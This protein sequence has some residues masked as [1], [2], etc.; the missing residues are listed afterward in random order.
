MEISNITI[1]DRESDT[2]I[3]R[4]VKR[5]YPSITQAIIE[6]S[7]RNGLIKIDNKKV[8]SNYRVQTNQILTVAIA[9]TQFKS[10]KKQIVSVSDHIIN[11]FRRSILFYD[12]DIIVINKD[13]GLATQRG[14]KIKHSVDDII[15]HVEEFKDLNPKLVHRLDKDT[16][17][18]LII[19]ANVHSANS[20]TK[21]FREKV[22][23]K[24]YLALTL[25]K[26]EKNYGT[27]D[28]P[29]AKTIENNFEQVTKSPNANKAITNY[30]LI[31][32]ISNEVSLV[33]FIPITG[34]THQIRVH[35]KIMN[36]PIIG[37]TKYGYF[38]E[39]LMIDQSKLNLHSWKI[40]IDDLYGKKYNFTA[41]I[42]KYMLS[43]MQELGLKL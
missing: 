26:P 23:D 13:S 39:N 17:G 20:L 40:N 7:L 36:M 38:G 34:K 6:K 42:P 41:P 15:K 25:G 9:I 8:K 3:D 2:R 30:R 5:Y 1:S 31:D 14:S 29:I 16:S 10:L 32:N 33:E 27:I 11:D 28:I 24:R 43:N 35:A 22:I 19:A 18:I 21:Y 12:H 37:D 4:L